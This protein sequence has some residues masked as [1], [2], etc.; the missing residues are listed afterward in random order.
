M[1]DFPGDPVE[2]RKRDVQRGDSNWGL[3]TEQETSI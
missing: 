3:G 2:E 1:W